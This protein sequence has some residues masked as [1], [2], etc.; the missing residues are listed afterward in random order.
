MTK[1]ERDRLR[2][3]DIASEYRGY[4][5]RAHKAEAQVKRLRGALEKVRECI[6]TDCVTEGS[7]LRDQ[8][9]LAVIDEALSKETNDGE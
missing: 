2:A 9:A 5:S 8:E 7:T 3:E 6:W 4:R 1:A